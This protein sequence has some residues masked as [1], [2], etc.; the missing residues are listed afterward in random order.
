M[1]QPVQASVKSANAI[2]HF[3]LMRYIAARKVG[4][5]VTSSLHKELLLLG[6]IFIKRNKLTK[7]YGGK[8]VLVNSKGI[9]AE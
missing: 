5:V 6:D 3:E 8:S 4:R 7:S 9:N 1:G 2:F